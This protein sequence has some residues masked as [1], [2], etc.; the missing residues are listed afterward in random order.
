MNMT[1]AERNEIDRQYKVANY[2]EETD[3]MILDGGWDE[4]EVL[5][6]IRS[7]CTISER[8]GT[9][10]HKSGTIYRTTAYQFHN[11]EDMFDWYKQEL[12]HGGQASVHINQMRIEREESVSFLDHEQ[13]IRSYFS[14]DEE[15]DGVWVDSTDGPVFVSNEGEV[16]DFSKPLGDEL[17]PSYDYDAHKGDE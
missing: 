15:E 5:N 8:F 14:E 2:D 4:G 13:E 16:A 1:T 10:L 3:T 11:M 9:M 17:D 6:H 12:L 7:V